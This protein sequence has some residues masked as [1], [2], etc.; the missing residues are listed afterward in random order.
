MATRAD[1]RR[2]QHLVELSKMW[3]CVKHQLEPI[4]KAHGVAHSLMSRLVETPEYA[5]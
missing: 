4:R 1:G 5:H 3:N 2:C